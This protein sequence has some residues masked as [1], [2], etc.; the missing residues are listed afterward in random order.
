MTNL[1]KSFILLAL[2]LLVGGVAAPAVA[3]G[4]QG[5]PSQ[6][7]RWWKQEKFQKEL[8]LTADQIAK[9]DAINQ[10]AEPT[11]RAQKAAFDKCE[12]K[13]SKIISD[14]KSDE[15]QVLQ[16]TERLDAA[17]AELNKTRTL[18]LFRMRRILT[19]E[20]NAKMKEMHDRD[21]SDRGR[22]RGSESKNQ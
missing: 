21:H 8:S 22:P 17:R 19:D 1:R 6:G 3:Q 9:L 15:A 5:S 11:L 14:A 18:Q 7:F 2:A 4:S 20:Q 16:A 10:A 12:Q 13:L